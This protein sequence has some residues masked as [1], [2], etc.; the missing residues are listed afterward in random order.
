MDLN[1][2]TPGVLRD[3]LRGVE[4]S[5]GPLFNVLNYPGKVKMCRSLLC[6]VLDDYLAFLNGRFLEV[7]YSSKGPSERFQVL[8]PNGPSPL[9]WDRP[10]Q[11]KQSVTLFN[12]EKAPPSIDPWYQP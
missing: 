9:S 3:F 2:W 6:L 8:L 11:E 12:S 5:C 10:C 4:R 7:P 1:K